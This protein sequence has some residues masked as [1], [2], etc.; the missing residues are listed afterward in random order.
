MVELPEQ[1][2]RQRE[3]IDAHFQQANPPA[4]GNPPV[5]PTEPPVDPTLTDPVQPPDDGTQTPPPAPNYDALL[6]QAE[7]RYRSLQGMYNADNAKRKESDARIA[8]LEQLLAS[9]QTQQANTP[10]PPPQPVKLLSEKEATEYGESIDVMRKVTREEISDVAARISS[11]EENIRNI[12][13][14]INTNIVP[15]VQQ[16]AQRQAENANDFFWRTLSATVPNWQQVNNDPDFHAWLMEMDPL[17]GTNRQSALESAHRALDSGRVAAFFSAFMDATGKYKT[18]PADP[19]S[20]STPSSELERQVAPGR[21]R[22]SSPPQGQTAQKYSRA[23]IAKFFDDVRSGRY[24]GR[25]AERN[26]IERDIFAAQQENR[27]TG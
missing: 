2:R 27:I 8:Q 26:R 9:M 17:L 1:L 19:S 4:D 18:P 14:G 5:D 12:M 10:P 6:Q 20:R 16:V 21:S 25:E 23:D 13:S 11:L 22:S 3:E 24:K 15:Q 7:Q